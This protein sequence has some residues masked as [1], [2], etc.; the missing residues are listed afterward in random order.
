MKE[1]KRKHQEIEDKKGKVKD[2]RKLTGNKRKESVK[3]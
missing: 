3:M 1:N 2:M